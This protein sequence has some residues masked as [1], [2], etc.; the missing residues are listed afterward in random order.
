MVIN[1]KYTKD[2]VL[3]ALLTSIL[4]L[5]EQLLSFI[6]NVQLTFFL[7][8][9]YSKKL[10]IVKSSLIILIYVII[11]NLLSGSF[12][13][14]FIP[15]MLIGLLLIPLSLNTI[16]KKVNSNL[17][18]AILGIMYSFIF[19]F[20]NIIPGCIMFNLTFKEYLINDLYWEIILAINSFLTILLLYNACSKIFDIY[21]R[22][23]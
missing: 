13:L 5:Q 8:V 16:F 3:I 23:C 17:Y 2:L 21:L 15:F 22:G 18:L 9:L 19:S 11:D 14:L 1:M 6:P 10:G 12:S 7:I 4:F 20:I